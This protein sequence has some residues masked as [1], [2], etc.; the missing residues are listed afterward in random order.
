MARAAAGFFQQANAVDPHAAIGRLGHVIEGQQ[1]TE[2]RSAPPSPPRSGPTCAPGR[3]R[4][5]RAK[6]GRA[7]SPPPPAQHERVAERISS[8]VRL[9]AMMPAMRA[10]AHHVT[11]LGIA[12]EDEIKGGGL[13]ADAAFR[14]RLAQ[15]HVLAGDVHH[16]GGSG[17]VRDGSVPSRAPRAHLAPRPGLG[18]AQ[19]TNT[20]PRTSSV[21]SPF[22]VRVAV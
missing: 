18:L 4:R 3:S 21:L 1:A 20:Q 5:G 2:R 10:N 13:H 7:R 22:S 16:M 14:Q 6:R 11:L 17:G 12:G 19:G 15:R 8:W 9:A